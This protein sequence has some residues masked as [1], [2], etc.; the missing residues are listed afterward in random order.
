M[1]AQK[2]AVQSKSKFYH[3]PLV[4]SYP[5]LNVQAQGS[6]ESVASPSCFILR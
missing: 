5:A 2:N 3:S 4:V 6:N 1:G